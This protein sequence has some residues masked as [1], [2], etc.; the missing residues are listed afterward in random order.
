MR[1]WFGVLVGLIVLL[2]GAANA[3]ASSWTFHPRKWKLPPSWTSAVFHPSKWPFSLF[4]VPEIATD[5]NSGTTI[6][7]LPVFLFSDEHNQI[8]QIFAPDIAINTILGATGTFRYLAYPSSDTQYYAIAGGSQNI[9]RRV[10]LFFTTGRDRKKWWS[11]EGRLFFEEDPT[12]RFFGLGNASSQGNETNYTTEQLYF[13]ATLGINFTQQLQ[14]AIT[15]QPWYVRIHEGALDNLP[16]ID[17]RFPFLKG[18]HGGSELLTQF[19]FSYDTRDSVDIPR[20]GGLYRVFYGV[21]DRALASSFSYNQLGFELR[22]YI[23]VH[24]RVTL[25]GRIYSQ[26]T[27]A[28][29]ETPFW[30]MSRLG[31]EEA[32]LFGQQ[33]LRGYGAGRYVQNNVTDFND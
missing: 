16:Q 8:K 2:L 20:K 14:L 18:I 17:S 13:R 30:A 9:A 31:G 27:P 26:Y 32:F 12:E 11:F 22:H 5:P 28:G 6:G 19:V 3:G 25:A 7:I 24:P 15:E 23:T 4:P 1:R 29:G 10:D 33:T 21:A